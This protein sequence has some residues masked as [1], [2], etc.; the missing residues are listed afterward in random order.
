MTQPKCKLLDKPSEYEMDRFGNEVY[1]DENGKY[2]NLTGPALITKNSES[3]YKHG[4]LHNPHGPAIEIDGEKAY[5]INGIRLTEEEFE[6]EQY[7]ILKQ[8][9]IDEFGTEIWRDFDGQYHRD[10]DLPAMIYKNGNKYWFKHGKLH[11]LNGPA[12]EE[13]DGEKEYWIEGIKLTEEEFEESKDWEKFEEETENEIEELEKNLKRNLYKTDDLGTKK[14][15]NEI[16][17]LHREDGPAAIFTDGS[18]AYY[19]KGK[20]IQ[21]NEFYKIP[22]IDEDG[23]KRWFNKDGKL[24]R[25]NDLPAVKMTNKY[26]AWYINGERHRRNGP[27][28]IYPN[29]TYK[30][31]VNGKEYGEREFILL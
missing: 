29:G 9:Q 10:N 31:Y 2:H 25:D 28:I 13:I 27:A 17:Q 16:G 26:K 20:P 14:W 5:W 22:R 19:L 15:R 3:W 11:N 12:T 1:R 18:K 30:W 24:H 21:E 23:N 6:E 4:K 8:P 7:P